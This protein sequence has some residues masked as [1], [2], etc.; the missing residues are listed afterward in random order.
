WFNTNYHYIVPELNERKPTLKTNC[1]LTYYN[2]A[3]EKLCIN[4]MPVLVGPIT[5]VSI[6]KG[7]EQSEFEHIIDD[8][9]PLNMQILQ[10]LSEVGAEW[11]QIDEPIFSTDVSE[12]VLEITEKVYQTIAK[13]VP[14]IKVIF[15]TYFEK[16]FHYE[17]ITH[18]PV[19]ALGIDFV[20]GDSL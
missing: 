17:R 14:G 18:L 9:R 4:G 11:V 19:A 20:H 16:L 2:V 12:A 7:Y 3:K 6:A 5:Y 10:D 13:E 15:Q 1:T 8:F